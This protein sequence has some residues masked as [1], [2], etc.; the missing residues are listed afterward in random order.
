MSSSSSPPHFLSLPR[1]DSF[2]GPPAGTPDTSTSSA[3]DFDVDPSTGFM[4]P[5]PP[6]ARLPAEW[7]PWE[8]ALDEARRL[9]TASKGAPVIPTSELE[10]S[11]VMLRRAHHVLAW[12]MHFYINTLPPNAPIVIPRSI[13]LP[14]LSVSNYLALP[15]L[16]T[17]SDD[18]LYNWKYQA[19]PGVTP[20]APTTNNI[21]VQTSFT[22]T[23][24]EA[25]FYL[26]SAYI[27]LRGA[28]ALALMSLIM[29]EV[30]VR[31]ALAVRRISFYL[32]RLAKIIDELTDLLMAGQDSMEGG[33]KWVFE[34][35]GE[36]GYEHLKHPTAQELSGPSA[37]QSTL[38]VNDTFGTDVRK[39]EGE[40]EGEEKEK[41]KGGEK[42][43][44][45]AR[46]QGY[47]PRHHRAFLRHLAANPR[48]LRFF[49]E[50]ETAHG[51]SPELFAGYNAAV[52]ALRAFRDS[53]LRIVALYIIGPSRR[54]NAGNRAAAAPAQAST[55]S[56][57]VKGT[58]GHGCD[59]VLEGGARPDERGYISRGS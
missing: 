44:F 57:T 48:P 10:A 26:T 33:R 15:P 31:D 39:G 17:Y 2:T 28:A 40:R 37:G 6:L 13:S 30:F 5:Q 36:A 25:H 35:V 46:M 32:Q 16:L 8:A 1:P 54:V 53:H 58:G 52:R 38:L 49:V 21:T 55:E 19:P 18:V 47:M 12:T 22:S 29:D 45:L 3:H 9:E 23:P 7:E 34:G 14:L 11:E 24:S 42:M 4:P 59:D 20:I 51:Q 27:E 50:A 41:E 43:S 56:P